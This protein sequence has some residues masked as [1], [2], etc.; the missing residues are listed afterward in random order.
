MHEFT[1]CKRILEIVEEHL[2]AE[3]QKKII[4]IYLDLGE[5]MCVDKNALLF[6]FSALRNNTFASEASLEIT[7]TPGD[8]MR[9]RSMEIE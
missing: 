3:P 2:Q 8:E 4:K 9:V 5:R 7:T 6:S 1:L